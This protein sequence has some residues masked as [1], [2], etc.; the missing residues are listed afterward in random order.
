MLG[1]KRKSLSGAPKD[2]H[3]HV[4]LFRNID[5][6]NIGRVLRKYLSQC[7][8][9][10]VKADC[11]FVLPQVISTQSGKYSVGWSFVSINIFVNIYV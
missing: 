11:G 6:G 1:G 7:T 10:K 3:E 8:T 4:T 9:E 5:D 2:V